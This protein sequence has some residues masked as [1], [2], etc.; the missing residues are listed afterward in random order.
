VPNPEPPGAPPEPRAGTCDF[1]GGDSGPATEL[2]EPAGSRFYLISRLRF[3]DVTADGRTA[4]FDLD[5]R[6]SDMGD[7]QGCFVPDETGFDG[8]RGLDN[9]L[10][11]NLETIE[12]IT[13]SDF[14]AALAADISAGRLVTVIE[15]RNVSSSSEDDCIDLY[16]H[17]ARYPSG[18]PVLD[19][20]GVPVDNQPVELIPNT[21]RHFS[22]AHIVPIGRIRASGGSFPMGI[23]ISGGK[24]LIDIQAAELDID[25][26]G[27]TGLVGGEL[28]VAD[29][30]RG[31]ECGRVP[32]PPDLVDSFLTDAADLR[33]QADGTCA[34]FSVAMQFSEVPVSI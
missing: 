23:D 29:F 6:V 28:R 4:A 5:G 22:A 7:A 3:S 34:S 1:R 27:G 9:V 31:A 16:V 33:P 8:R 14:T 18:G 32:F 11:A 17:D 24:F 12:S 30:V 15:L 10:G 21:A 13:D 2:C 19:R 25:H 26:H 20:E